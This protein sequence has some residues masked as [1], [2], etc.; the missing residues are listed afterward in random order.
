MEARHRRGKAAGEA[1]VAGKRVGEGGERRRQDPV[2]GD[3]AAGRGI[4]REVEWRPERDGDRRPANLQHGFD[5]D[6]LGRFEQRG[7][8][9][10]DDGRGVTG[11]I[12][13]GGDLGGCRRVID[14]D[15]VDRGEA[16]SERGAE[17]RRDGRGRVGRRLVGWA[18]LDRKDATVSR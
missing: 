5:E 9:P 1:R 10:D 12:A 15:L 11:P 6:R 17:P 8:R 4:C 14:D 18:G 16:A 3:V 13:D 7:G 2:G